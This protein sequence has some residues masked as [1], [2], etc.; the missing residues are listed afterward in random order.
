M[1]WTRSTSIL[2]FRNGKLNL[3]YGLEYLAD[4]LSVV[5]SGNVVF[6]S[7]NPS[8]SDGFKWNG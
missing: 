2:G 8:F 4:R 6:S 1:M 5:A 7:T 3:T